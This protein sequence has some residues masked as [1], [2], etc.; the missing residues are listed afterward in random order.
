VQMFDAGKARMIVLLYGEKTVTICYAVFIW[1][2][3][4]FVMAVSA[5]GI[6]A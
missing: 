4:V 2:R 5:A 6:I 3:N 1:Y